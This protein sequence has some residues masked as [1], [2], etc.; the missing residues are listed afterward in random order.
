ASF[1]SVGTASIF[2]LSCASHP[3][4]IDSAYV[5]PLKYKDYDCDQIALEMDHVGQRTTEL[6]HR[7]DAEEE[8]D[9]WQMGIGLVLF[10]PALFWLE[11]GDGPEAAEYAQ[12]KGEFEALRETSVAKKCSLEDVQS[13]REIIE[14]EQKEAASAAKDASSAAGAQYED[15]VGDFAREQ[16]CTKGVSFNGNEDGYDEYTLLCPGGAIMQVR[17]GEAGCFKDID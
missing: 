2:L 16:E 5:S 1:L 4:D 14:S 12:L 10:W 3:D 11:G 17:C 7:L 13:P 6:Y 8:A 9:A 15:L